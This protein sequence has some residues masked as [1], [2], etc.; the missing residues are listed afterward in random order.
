MFLINLPP[1]SVAAPEARQQRL[2]EQIAI[3]FIHGWILGRDP[4][5]PS[6]AAVRLTYK[7]TV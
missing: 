7:Y 4:E 1:Y 5:L 3:H 6:I 2:W